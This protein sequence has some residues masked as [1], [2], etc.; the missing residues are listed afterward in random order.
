MSESYDSHHGPLLSFNASEVTNS[1]FA[2][3]NYSELP[4]YGRPS[5]T[6]PFR[7]HFSG[8]VPKVVSRQMAQKWLASPGAADT[9]VVE[10]VFHPR[11]W[12]AELSKFRFLLS[13]QGDEIQ[14]PK[15]VEALLVLTI[16]I[17]QRGP[18][19]VANDLLRLG[20]PVVAVDEWDEVTR[21]S[22]ARWWSELSPRLLSFRANCLTTDGFWRMITGAVEPCH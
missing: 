21:G 5:M 22:L 14:T 7:S 16:P 1:T 9:G 20:F 15:V 19:R 11:A 4:F 12:W 8:Q 18:Y 3:L 6:N 13:P 2:M 17:T 10:K